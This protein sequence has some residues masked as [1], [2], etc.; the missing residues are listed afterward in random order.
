MPKRGSLKSAGKRQQNA[1]S[2]NAAFAMLHGSFSLAAAQL[3]VKMT[4][5]LQES[6]CCR[7]TTNFCSAALRKLQRNFRFR[8][9]HV[10]VVGFRGVGFRTG[11]LLS[12]YSVGCEPED[13]REEHEW[14][15]DLVVEDHIVAVR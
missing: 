1:T 12:L 5:A 14:L 11:Y 6:H 15:V 9:W 13:V 10:T 7:A 8:L 3:F 2:C 4:S